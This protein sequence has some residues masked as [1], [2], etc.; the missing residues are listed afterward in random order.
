MKL[1]VSL[2]TAAVLSTVAVATAASSGMS[3]SSR[4]Y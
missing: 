3:P 2:A 1:I 4:A